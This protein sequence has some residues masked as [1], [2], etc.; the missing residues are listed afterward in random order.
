MEFH[1]VAFKSIDGTKVLRGYRPINSIDTSCWIGVVRCKISFQAQPEAKIMP[2]PQVTQGF[3]K[4]IEV[5]QGGIHIGCNPAAKN[6]RPI[7]GN[8]ID[9]VFF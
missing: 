8:R 4:H 1:G 7:N 9:F 5:L 3:N 6:I 2:L